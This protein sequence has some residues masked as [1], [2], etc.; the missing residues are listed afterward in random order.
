MSKLQ[1]KSLG[2]LALFLGSMAAPLLLAGCDSAEPTGTKVTETTQAQQANNEME[3]F[4]KNQS[5]KK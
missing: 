2:A 5:K 1:R 3:N 4:M